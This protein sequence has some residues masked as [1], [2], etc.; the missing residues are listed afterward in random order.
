M[1]NFTPLVGIAIPLM[2]ANVDTDIIIPGEELIRLSKTGLGPGLFASWRY[3]GSSNSDRIPNPEFVLNDPHYKDA[4]ILLAG[5]NF[6]CGSSREPAVWALRDWGFRCVIAPSFGSI[7]HSNCFKNGLLPIVLPIE[8]IETIAF[9]V[10]NSK[11]KP[12]LSVDLAACTLGTPQGATLTFEMS[13]F[14]R[15]MLLE[16]LDPIEAVLRYQQQIDEFQKSDMIMRPWI[17]STK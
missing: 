3:L 12:E 2:V 16:E 10:I 11:H 9:Q 7:F 5:P 13:D 14:H 8:Q 15:T 17:Y 6:A 4:K 1:S